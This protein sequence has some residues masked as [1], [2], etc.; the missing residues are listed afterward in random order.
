MCLKQHLYPESYTFLNTI[1]VVKGPGISYQT[2]SFFSK[3]DKDKTLLL[4]EGGGI[5]DFIM[6]SRFIPEL[7]SKYNEN[8]IIFLVMDRLVWLF[9]HWFKSIP[10]LQTIQK[11]IHTSLK[12]LSPET[13][14]LSELA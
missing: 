10:N 8:K 11:Q 1:E 13:S 14:H 12:G 5:G 7:C 9:Q 3:H 6:K 4:Y 2:M